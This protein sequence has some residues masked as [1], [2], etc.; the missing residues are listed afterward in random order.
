MQTETMPYIVEI[1]LGSPSLKRDTEL[2]NK[3]IRLSPC[4]NR[5]TLNHQRE[6]EE[7]DQSD[8]MKSKIQKVDKEMPKETNLEKKGKGRTATLVW[9]N[10]IM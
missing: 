1:P 8:E 6:E 3:A 10:H 2:V 5:M 4:L 9:K 7:D